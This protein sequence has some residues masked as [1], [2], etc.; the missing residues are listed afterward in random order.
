MPLSQEETAKLVDAMVDI[1][2]WKDQ[3]W[4][5]SALMIAARAIRRGRHLTDQ[6]KLENLLKAIWWPASKI[7]S[8]KAKKAI[9]KSRKGR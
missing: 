1:E 8:Q 5:R 9:A 6:E 2:P 4:A 3:I 7:K